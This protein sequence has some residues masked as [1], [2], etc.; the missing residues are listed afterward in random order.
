MTKK[1]VAFL[2][3]GI[4]AL[5]MVAQMVIAAEGEEG[6]TRGRGRGPGAGRGRAEGAERPEGRPGR[7]EGAEGRGLAMRR[8][9]SPLMIAL[10][11]NKDGKLDKAEIKAASRVLA[12]MA[13]KKTGEI[14][15]E[16]LRPKRPEG[17]GAVG[18]EGD[19][20]GEGRPE[21]GRQ[22]GGRGRGGREG[23]GRGGREGA[24]EGAGRGRPE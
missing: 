23:A 7:G 15:A 19:R 18:R 10:D 24:G 8:P 13:D 9:A 11:R 14:S 6:A 17:A 4:M 3:V 21:G 12:A 20:E 2:L 16:K 22:G 1:H 5:G